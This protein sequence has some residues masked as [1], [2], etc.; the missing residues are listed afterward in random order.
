MSEIYEHEQ[1]WRQMPKLLFAELT[2]G[3]AER[4][5]HLASH[6]SDRLWSELNKPVAAVR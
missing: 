2:A 5:G 6:F 4:V 1:L 3:A